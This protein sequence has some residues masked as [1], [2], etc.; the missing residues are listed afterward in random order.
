MMFRS[1]TIQVR[2]ANK[3]GR[4]E[5]RYRDLNA[6][7]AKLYW[8]G[9]NIFGAYRAR[10]IEFDGYRSRVIARKDERGQRTWS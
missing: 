10:L 5:T 2:N 1:Y 4:Y 8:E 3:H 7:Q 9:L 6:T